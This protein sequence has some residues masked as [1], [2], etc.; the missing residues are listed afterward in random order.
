[1][2]EAVAQDLTL[3]QHCLDLVEDQA[4]VVVVTPPVAVF[5][6]AEMVM[7]EPLAKVTLVEIIS[8]TTAQVVAVVAQEVWGK[9]RL[10]VLAVMVVQV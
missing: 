7:Q 3:E 5:Q 10:L 2:A 1:L 4:V 9:M 6:T 8:A